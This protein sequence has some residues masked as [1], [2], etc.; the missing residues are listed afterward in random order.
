MKSVTLQQLMMEELINMQ[1]E[2]P[3]NYHADD[4]YKPTATPEEEDDD[5]NEDDTFAY[6]PN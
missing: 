1:G 6:V 3:R 2:P 4:G 5:N